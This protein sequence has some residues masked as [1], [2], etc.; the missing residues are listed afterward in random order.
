MDLDDPKPFLT[1][2]FLPGLQ[3]QL[4]A[5]AIYNTHC[6]ISLS[7]SAQS[8]VFVV[9]I[10]LGIDKMPHKMENMPGYF[11]VMYHS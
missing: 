11:D 8:L 3:L 6:K 7:V 9:L 2:L 5:K 10:P 1:P 4:R